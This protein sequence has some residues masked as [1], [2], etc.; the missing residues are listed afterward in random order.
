[1]K[2]W[3]IQRIYTVIHTSDSEIQSMIKLDHACQWQSYSIWDSPW[4]CRLLTEWRW[5]WWHGQNW[6]DW[7]VAVHSCRRSPCQGQGRHR[8][9]W[10]FAQWRQPHHQST[11]NLAC[12]SQISRTAL[13]C[14]SELNTH[15]YTWASDNS[16]Q[17]SSRLRFVW[18]SWAIDMKSANQG[19]RHKIQR[20]KA[21]Y[22]CHPGKLS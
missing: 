16:S 2:I 1:M 21:D 10:P 7:Y 6:S 15:S 11:R 20:T 4:S 8:M 3:P 5:H 13:Y 9:A 18:K 14:I 17:Y 19:S 22:V 12:V